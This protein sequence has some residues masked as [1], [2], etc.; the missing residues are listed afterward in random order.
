MKNI[1]ADEDNRGGHKAIA[2]DVRQGSA[3]R[4]VPEADETVEEL[5]KTN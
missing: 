3:G 1:A 2:A 4:G 5:E